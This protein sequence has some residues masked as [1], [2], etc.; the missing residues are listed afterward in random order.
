MKVGVILGVISCFILVYFI[1]EDFF[2]APKEQITI[3]E[4]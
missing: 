2:K 1:F 4:I 3:N